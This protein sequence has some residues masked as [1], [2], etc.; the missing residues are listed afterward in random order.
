M[1]ERPDLLKKLV[2]KHEAPDA[3]VRGTAMAELDATTTRTSQYHPGTELPEK[4]WI[5]RFAKSHWFNDFEIYRG[6][7]HSQTA[8]PGLVQLQKTTPEKVS[9]STL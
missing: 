7:D 8:A 4:S 9:T 2:E 5:Y 3:T 1:L 6:K